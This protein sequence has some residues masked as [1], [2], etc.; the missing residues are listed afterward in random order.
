MFN[1]VNGKNAILI[2]CTFSNNTASTD[3]GGI[4]NYESS[5]TLTDCLFSGN[6]AFYGGG[7]LNWP[8]SSPTLNGCTFN[9]NSADYGGGMRNY[10]N[11]NPYVN[12]CVFNDNTATQ[13]A[14]GMQNHESS[15]IVHHCTFNNNSAYDGGAVLNYENCDPNFAACTFTGNSADDDGGGLFNYC[16]DSTVT[17]CTFS[18][19][20]AESSGGGMY[21]N[22]DMS[23]QCMPTLHG[24]TFSGNS[25][26]YG[27]GMYNESYDGVCNLILTDS[28]FSGNSAEFHGGGMLNYACYGEFNPIL[29]NCTFSGNSA[30]YEGGG[31]NSYGN[32]GELNLILANCTFSGNSAGGFGGGMYVGSR[33]YSV[34][35]PILTN[36]IFWGNLASS[37]A[38][39]I[40]HN[41]SY[42]KVTY[43]DVQ[44]G[45]YGTGNIDVDPLFINSGYW[46]PN[47]TPDIPDDDFWIDGDYRL[48]P[49]SPCI[50]AGT[51][52]GVYEDIEG[53]VRPWDLPWVD[54]NG[55]EPE[56][57][58]G[59]YEF[60]NSAPVA[61]AGPNQVVYA[62][63]AGEADVLLDGTYSYDPDGDE[64]TYQW[65]WTIND[66]LMVSTGGDGLVD[67]LDLFML[68]QAWL[69]SPDSPDWDS[70]CDIV[71]NGA[72][73]TIELPIGEHVI[74]LV[75]NDG[76]ADSEPNEVVVNVVGPIEGD[77]WVLPPLIIRGGPLEQIMAA[78]RLPESIGLED[79]EQEE[80]LIL[81]PAEIEATCQWFVERHG[82][83][84]S[85]AL[86]SKDELLTAVEENGTVELQVEGKLTSG[87]YFYGSDSIFIMA[88][89]W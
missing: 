19:N 62:G 57:D 13:N 55:P 36:C 43:S 46:D 12:H 50:D 7:M 80:T 45:Y 60:V 1:V 59:A 69:S 34:C 54:N 10:A 61:C 65:S 26:D 89:P 31:I 73:P 29:K 28:K 85:V 30:G 82:R 32:G 33:Y 78:I 71:P 5:P 22:D 77:M 64:L 58:M 68:A 66:E 3:G 21:N 39:Q 11:S 37:S 18:G 47:G 24:C 51:D 81:Y 38:A 74:E 8:N 52:A 42:V 53:N 84:K 20:S 25:A 14:G 70:R 41:Q 75:V 35:N 67:G 86:F 6:S 27:G 79:I 40:Y 49:D 76:I 16:S 2:D 72:N 44:Y 87:Q 48:Q 4:A 9:G 56:F 23:G 63:V 88:L 17:N 83:V 15:P